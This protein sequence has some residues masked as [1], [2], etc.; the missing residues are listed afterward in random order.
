MKMNVEQKRCRMFLKVN[1]K[2]LANEAK[3]IRKAERL[4][5]L[6]R[7]SK[8]ERQKKRVCEMDPVV[9]GQYDGSISLLRNHRVLRVRQES[10]STQLAYAAIRGVPYREVEGFAKTE[11][12]WERIREKICRMLWGAADRAQVSEWLIQGRLHFGSTKLNRELLG[13][14]F[15]QPE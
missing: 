11:P 7:R 6:A 10:R 1:L 5:K 2:S 4:L 3:E 13:E 14:A 9:A 15:A 12:D 8:A